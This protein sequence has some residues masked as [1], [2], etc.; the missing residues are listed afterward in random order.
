MPAPPEPP[1]RVPHGT[2]PEADGEPVDLAEL[3]IDG[4]RELMGV[5]LPEEDPPPTLNPRTEVP[6][7]AAAE[8]KR[9]FSS[10]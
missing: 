9:R 6:T 7:T 5:R 2:R 3:L 4:L 8:P 1:P 10:H